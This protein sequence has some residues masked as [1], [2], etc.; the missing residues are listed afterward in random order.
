M[1]KGSEDSLGFSRAGGLRYCRSKEEE[2]RHC[3]LEH[4]ASK[5]LRL[6]VVFFGRKKSEERVGGVK[7]G[8]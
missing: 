8:R 1:R 4:G 3:R 7:V 6:P 2:V 5:G